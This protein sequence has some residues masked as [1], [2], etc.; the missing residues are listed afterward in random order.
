MLVR[1]CVGIAGA[2]QHDID[3]GLVPDKTIGG[4]DDA[5]GAALMHQKAER[6]GDV[7]E[8]MRHQPLRRQLAHRRGEA[9]G[10]RED[11]AHREHHQRAD[12]TLAGSAETPLARVLVHHVKADH[13]DVPH[14]VGGGAP[15]HF[16]LGV[17]RR[18]LGD[19]RDGGTCPSPSRA[20]SAGASTSRAWS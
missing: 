4:V 11:V 9:L 1:R 19:A 16:V 20:S 13:H 17:V 2:E 3:P 12:P 6:V 18:G 14:P 7:G 15:D 5:A 8:L 10:L